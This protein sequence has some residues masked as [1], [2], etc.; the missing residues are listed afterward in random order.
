M[1]SL[2]KNILSESKI[3]AVVGASPKPGRVSG[4]IA[5][6]LSEVG[7]KVYP[8]NPLY[9]EVAGLKCY[10][11]LSEIKIKID[12]VNIFR[13]SEDVFPIVEEAAKIGAK[14]IWMQLG[15]VNY[16]AENFAITSGLKVIMDKC[17]MVEYNKYF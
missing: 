7:Y 3:I 17:I 5:K 4:T 8:V 16:K 1:D 2:I 9:E 14:N 12:I 13:K 6:F 11:N 15:I 10:T